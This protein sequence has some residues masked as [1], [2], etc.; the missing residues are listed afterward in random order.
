[1]DEKNTL[2]LDLKHK[3][4]IDTIRAKDCKAIFFENAKVHN[5][6]FCE[7]AKLHNVYKREFVEL[8]SYERYVNVHANNISL[9]KASSL[10][11]CNE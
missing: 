9:Q 10:G 4:F 6:I 1:M 5:V 3:L 8:I 7:S 11:L 2:T